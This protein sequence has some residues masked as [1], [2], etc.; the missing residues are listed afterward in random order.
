[1]TLFEKLDNLL[2]TQT[3]KISKHYQI[4]FFFR[5]KYKTYKNIKNTYMKRNNTPYTY[6]V[7]TYNLERKLVMTWNQSTRHTKWSTWGTMVHTYDLFHQDTI[8]NTGCRN[9]KAS[10]IRRDST[11]R[12]RTETRAE[13][14]RI[15]QPNCLSKL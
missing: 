2:K 7:Y 3:Y 12:A 11:E 15:Q 6:C 4:E 9:T 1:M 5:T 8:S 13:Q 10:S 14:C